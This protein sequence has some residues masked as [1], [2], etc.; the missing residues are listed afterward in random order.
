MNRPYM[1]VSVWSRT[2]SEGTKM[3]ALFVL[4]KK[5]GTITAILPNS[6]GQSVDLTSTQFDEWHSFAVFMGHEIDY[7]IC[8]DTY[9]ETARYTHK[10]SA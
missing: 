3:L 8:D 10:Q 7:I 9:Q 4:S 1:N 5:N 6:D 2:A